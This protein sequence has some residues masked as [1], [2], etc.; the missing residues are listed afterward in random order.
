MRAVC[1]I[2]FLICGQMALAQNTPGC[3]ETQAAQLRETLDQAKVLTITAAA[4]IGDTPDYARWFGDYSAGHGEIV[5]ANLKSIVTAIR[6]GAVV[7]QCDTLRDQG[8]SSGEY[9]SVY[10]HEPYRIYLCPSFFNLPDLT[11]LKPGTMASDNGTKVGTIV[12]ELSHFD[13]V[14]R[15]ADHCYTRRA[16]AAMAS[17]DPVRAIDNADSYQY[18]T[19]DVTYYAR[20]PVTGKVI[21]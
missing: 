17:R 18:F 19:E 20:Q 13:P 8:C 3:D 10:P 6:S 11:A 7:T 12:H 14:A 4:A 16:C 1:L 15:T 2:V 5:R 9:A 21:P